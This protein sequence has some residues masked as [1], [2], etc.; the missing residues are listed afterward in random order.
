[1]A[2]RRVAAGFPVVTGVLLGCFLFVGDAATAETHG[3][4]IDSRY[5]ESLAETWGARISQ[6]L[7]PVHFSAS[8][9]IRSARSLV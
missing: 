2:L 8:T 3:Q 5:V 9:E 6:L 7:H 4:K 1:M